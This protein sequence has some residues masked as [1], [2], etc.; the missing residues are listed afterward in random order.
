MGNDVNRLISKEIL[1][2]KRKRKIKHESKILRER[3]RTTDTRS[4]VSPLFIGEMWEN[5]HS[6]IIGR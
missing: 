5:S 1:F 3:D 4:R 2:Y 6:Q